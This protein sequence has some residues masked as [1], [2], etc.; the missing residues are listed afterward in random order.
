MNLQSIS[1]TPTVKECVHIQ[2]CGEEVCSV[3]NAERSRAA[4]LR[5]PCQTQ[6][7]RRS[8]HQPVASPPG[9]TAAKYLV[10]VEKVAASKP[11][12]KGRKWMLWAEPNWYSQS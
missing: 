2:L 11:E 8:F 1:P 4:A 9:S 10:I 6:G 5:C 12:C 7:C 3:R